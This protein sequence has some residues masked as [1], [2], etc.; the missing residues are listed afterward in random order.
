VVPD[1]LI[2]KEEV[3]DYAGL[4]YVS[5]K[6]GVVTVKKAPLLHKEVKDYEKALC[7]KF[8]HRW[9]NSEFNVRRLESENKMLQN[10]LKK[11]S[12]TLISE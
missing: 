10:G 4:I 2:S 5:E 11:Y 7:T 8:Y 9:R 1:K 6:Y 3:P 12:N